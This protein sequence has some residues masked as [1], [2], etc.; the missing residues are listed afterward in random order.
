MW[1][2]ADRGR[3]ARG[4]RRGGPGGLLLAC[5]WVALCRRLRPEGDRAK[6]N[7]D[8]GGAAHPECKPPP[9]SKIIGAGGRRSFWPARAAAHAAG[10][11]RRRRGG[12]HPRGGPISKMTVPQPTNAVLEQVGW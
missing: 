3:G 2:A 8:V 5:A 10:P 11:P 1:L 12:A 4:G 9:C 7:W 6:T